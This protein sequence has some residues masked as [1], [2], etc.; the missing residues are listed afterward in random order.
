LKNIWVKKI[1][2]VPYTTKCKYTSKQFKKLPNLMKYSIIYYI[3]VHCPISIIYEEF[4]SCDFTKNIW[5]KFFIQINISVCNTY[6]FFC[7]NTI[8]WKITRI[9]R[10]DLCPKSIFNVFRNARWNGKKFPQNIIKCT[11]KLQFFAW[12]VPL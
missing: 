3:W 5:M 12:N 11:K 10:E 1:A 4:Y 6:K 7:K 9:V 2:I 8:I